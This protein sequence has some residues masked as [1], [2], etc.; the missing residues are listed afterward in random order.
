[1]NHDLPLYS[2]LYQFLTGRPVRPSYQCQV[3]DETFETGVFVF[4]PFE[5]SRFVNF[6]AAVFAAPLVESAFVDAVF[7]A[8]FNNRAPGF[9]LF[10]DANNLL[11][12]P[13]ACSHD[14]LL[15]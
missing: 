7:T 11:L 9:D 2:G 14:C 8:R 6:Q 13:I 12:G 4:E 5:P 3:R 1:M 15:L 10:E